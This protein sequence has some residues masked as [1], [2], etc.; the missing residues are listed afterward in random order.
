MY[1][2]LAHVAFRVKDMDASLR[3]YCDTLGC[4]RIFEIA[5]AEGRPWIVYL[6]IQDSQFVELFFNGD[7]PFTPGERDIAFMH[8]CLETDDVA[9]L[10]EKAVAA[11]YAGITAPKKGRDLGDHAMLLDPDGVRVELVKMHPDAPQYR[12]GAN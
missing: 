7:R 10:Y 1:K 12:G 2:R 11:G 5:D 3:F 8:F 9:A 6:R 4:R